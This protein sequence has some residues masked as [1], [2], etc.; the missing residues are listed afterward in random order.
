GGGGE[1][2]V[3]VVGVKLDVKSKELLTWALVKVAQSGDH[4]IALHVLDPTN[5]DKTSPLSL[6]KRFHFVLAAYEGFCNLKQIDLKLKFS[7][8]TPVR[9]VLAREARS[10]N[11][12]CLIVGPSETPHRIRSSVAVATFCSRNL[13]RCVSVIAVDNGKIL[14]QRQASTEGHSELRGFKVIRKKSIR[15]KIL[16]KGPSSLLTSTV[17]NEDSCCDDVANSIA[18]VPLSNQDTPSRS[19]WTRIRRVLTHNKL[20]SENSAPPKKSFLKQCISSGQSSGSIF[21]DRKH[22]I[23][24]SDDHN[25]SKLDEESGEIVVV[26][27]NSISSSDLVD[28]K[29]LRKELEGLSDKY[30]SI[31]RLFSYQEL[32]TAT[33]NFRSENF[34][35]RGGSS[36]VYK[37]SLPD[38]RELAVKILKSSE[39]VLKQYVSEI[40]IITTLSHKN[41]ISLVGFCFEDNNLLL[42]YDLLTRGSLEENLHG[43]NKLG[44][45][46]GW[47]ERYKTAIGIA[48]ALDHL[49]N[50]S[51]EPIIHRDV[52]SSNILLSDDFEPQLSDFGLATLASNASYDIDSF[53]VAGTFGYLAPEYFMHGRLDEKIDV[54]AFGVVLLELLSGRMPIDNTNPRG[55]ESVVMWAKH[56]L[57]GGKFSEL[58]DPDLCDLYD[59]DQFKNMV[60]AA[61]LCIRRAPKYRPKMCTVVKLL[62]GEPEIVKWA[63]QHIGSSEETEVDDDEQSPKTIQSFLNLALQNLDD[64]SLSSSSAEQ[65]ISVEEYLQGRW[66]RTSSFK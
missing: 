24:D 9:K 57:R 42:V 51:E 49:H 22:S 2:G 27:S 38:G 62:Q 8:G 19:G 52:K 58:L 31:C 44:G 36:Q 21:P 60:L 5:E 14:F 56:I 66:S 1:G 37:G 6:V 20:R 11:A 30:S 32:L 50:A 15:A 55:Q 64:D 65:M 61:S 16:G 12:R 34:I 40:Q 7:R 43:T 48:E 28:V 54:Y 35:G 13:P 47:T 18:L 41:I 59:H 63:E 39:D 46:F 26:G 29:L 25:S 17:S 4:V 45:S 3:V 33:S 23:R 53:D 10:C